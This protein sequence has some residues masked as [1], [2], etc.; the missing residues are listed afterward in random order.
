MRSIVRK[1]V[2]FGPDATHST[3]RK[4]IHAFL[5]EG[6]EVFG[7]TFRRHKINAGFVP[8]WRNVPLGVTKDRAYLRRLIS[9]LAAVVRVCRRGR[10]VRD[11]DAFYA[12]NFDQQVIAIA[13]KA[14]LRAPVRIVYEV[15][16]IQAFFTR[17]TLGGA[18][19]R[20]LERLA[21]RR[22]DLVVCSSPAFQRDHFETV[23]N[24]RGPFFIWENKVLAADMAAGAPSA[25][26]QAPAF[27]GR[28]TIGWF[29]TL[30]CVRSMRLL[31]DLAARFPDR[32]Q[33]YTR[34]VPT[35]TGLDEYKAIVDRHE[36]FVYEGEYSTPNDLAAMYGRVHFAW[37]FDFHDPGGNS[38]MLLPN[39]LYEGGLYGAV[40]L[41]HEAQETGRYVSGRGIGFVFAEPLEE[42]LA[43]FFDSVAQEDYL[44]KR[45]RILAARSDF[46]D[47]GRDTRALL[48]RISE[49]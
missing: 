39:R 16:D 35:E 45:R 46:V 27:D 29:G 4:R 12:R 36:N 32:L 3:V 7:F 33:I 48:A 24:Y 34:G 20:A 2:Y 9:V 1:I 49:L 40:M 43:A 31:S 41:A 47:D 25:P 5:A 18:V 22:T 44:R 37:C 30:R 23:Q 26:Q 14:I 6:V 15:P 13:S 21:L 8:D 11:A 38:D 10:E 42:T 17:K 19:F 28:W